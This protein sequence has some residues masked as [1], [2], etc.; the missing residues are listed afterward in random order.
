MNLSTQF[1]SSRNCWWWGMYKLNNSL[2]YCSSLYFFITGGK[3]HGGRQCFK[4]LSRHQVNSKEIGHSPALKESPINKGFSC[5]YPHHCY[6][7]IHRLAAFSHKLKQ[8]FASTHSSLCGHS[9]P[10][11]HLQV[12]RHLRLRAFYVMFR[13]VVVADRGGWYTPNLHTEKGAVPSQWRRHSLAQS[14]VSIIKTPSII[15]HPGT[16]WSRKIS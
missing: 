10:E 3:E 14:W 1:N 13:N 16:S 8:L 2:Y 6:T 12:Q 7:H 9:V 15:S 11:P 5:A 4:Q